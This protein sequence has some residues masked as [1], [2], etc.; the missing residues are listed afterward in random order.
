MILYCFSDNLPLKNGD[1]PDFPG[2]AFYSS[3]LP[4]GPRHVLHISEDAHLRRLLE[5]FLVKTMENH[6]NFNE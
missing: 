4:R 2:P 3:H 6:Q 1:F 5:N